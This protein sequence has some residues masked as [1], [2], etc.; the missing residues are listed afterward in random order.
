[1]SSVKTI[2]HVDDDDLLQEVLR[3][4][5]EGYRILSFSSPDEAYE[6]A[7]DLA[8]AGEPAAL[9]ILDI[10]L[11]DIPSR[12]EQRHWRHHDE[13]LGHGIQLGKMLRHVDAY[14]AT[15]IFFLSARLQ[16]DDTRIKLALR[17]NATC[18][19]KPVPHVR[20]KRELERV[21]GAAGEDGFLARLRQRLR[22]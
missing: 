12:E 11:P 14:A 9:F 20:L 16:T 18:F 22:P 15:P 10:T 13:P 21:L 2:I 4:Y 8:E 3:T 6:R 19:C 5:L 17:V 7:L 1:M